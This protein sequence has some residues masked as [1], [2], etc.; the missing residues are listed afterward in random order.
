MNYLE[1]LSGIGKW[2]LAIILLGTVCYMTIIGKIDSGVVISFA[3]AA[4]G[5]YFGGK[6]NE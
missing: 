5:F 2:S 1:L 6:K 4:L 3:S